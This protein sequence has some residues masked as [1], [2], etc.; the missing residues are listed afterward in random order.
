ML[1]GNE[2]KAVIL[3][4]LAACAKVLETCEHKEI[5]LVRGRMQAYRKILR[6]EEQEAHSPFM[7]A[8]GSFN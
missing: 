4:E 3:K 1:D 2:V 5:D 8:P 6:L 7:A